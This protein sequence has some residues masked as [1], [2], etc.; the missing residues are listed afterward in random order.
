MF[1]FATA[2]LFHVR[3]ASFE[4]SR[5]NELTV[6]FTSGSN[7][8]GCQVVLSCA[9]NNQAVNNCPFDRNASTNSATGSV[10]CHDKDPQKCDNYIIKVYDRL[11]HGN[12]SS[13]AAYALYNVTLSGSK[14]IPG[15]H[16]Y[17]D[18]Y[19]IHYD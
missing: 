18:M 14:L 5:K 15:N 9:T 7:A 1:I 16:N 19:S 10:L 13:V 3:N 12:V 2:G 17:S 4:E 6:N 8:Q 11:A